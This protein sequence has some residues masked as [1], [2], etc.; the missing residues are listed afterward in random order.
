MNRRDFI[1]L[2]GGAAAAWPLAARAQQ[3]E[4]MRRIALLVSGLPA[5]E[6]GPQARRTAFVQGLQELGW[7]DGRNVRIEYRFGLGDPDRLRKYAAELV[8]LA[9]DV[10]VAGGTQAALTLRGATRTPPI[11]FGNVLDPVGQ[12]LVASLARPSGNATGFMNIEFGVSAKSLELLKEI[13][14]R[15]TRVAV[16]RVSPVGI[17]S[18]GAIQ[19]VAPALGVELTPVLVREVAEIDQTIAAFARGPND[20]LIV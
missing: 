9:P 6:P 18:L 19:A 15:V 3:R 7:T 17:G 10:I 8:A 14:P 11:V 13:A 20:G 5:D 4:R 16:V 2:L 1:T 12:G